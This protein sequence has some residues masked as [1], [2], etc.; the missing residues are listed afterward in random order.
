[1]T[2][3]DSQFVGTVQNFSSSD[4]NGSVVKVDVEGKSYL[5]GLSPLDNLVSKSDTDGKVNGLLCTQKDSTFTILTKS[6]MH[7][8]QYAV[9]RLPFTI[10]A[11]TNIANVIDNFKQS[12][13]EGA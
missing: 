9:D 8:C 13:R 7:T 1:M 2:I 11:V 12:I 10:K 3:D 4:E 5:C 6:A